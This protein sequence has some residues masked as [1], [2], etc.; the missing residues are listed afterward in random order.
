MW[1]EKQTNTLK[2]LNLAEVD[3]LGIM[4][5]ERLAEKHWITIISNH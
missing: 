3:Y 4:L 5:D 1:S 2:T